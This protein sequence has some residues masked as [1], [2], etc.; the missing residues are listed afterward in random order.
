M[1]IEALKSRVLDNV[2][3]AVVIGHQSS[4]THESRVV[5]A[6][7]AFLRIAGRQDRDLT[8]TCMGDL[9]KQGHGPGHLDPKNLRAGHYDLTVMRADGSPHVIKALIAME[10]SPTRDGYYVSITC[11]QGSV[12]SVQRPAAPDPQQTEFAKL[13]EERDWLAQEHERLQFALNAYPDPFVIYDENLT[14]ISWNGAYAYTMVDDP[15]LLKRGMS[16]RDVLMLGVTNGRFPAAKENPEQWVNDRLSTNNLNADTEDNELENGSH[17]RLYRFRSDFGDYIVI[18]LDT[19]ELVRQKRV[20]ENAQSRLLAALNAYPAPFVI[21][22]PDDCIVVWNDAYSASMGDPDNPLTIGMHRNDVARIAIDAGKIVDA[23]GLE[24]IWKSAEH[25]RFDLKK[26]VQDLELPGDVHQR[27]LRSR[28]EN[29]DLVILR[30]DTTELV[31]QRRAVERYAERL[32]VA[33]HEITHQAFHDDLTGMGNR[34]HLKQR[35]EEFIEQKNAT[36]AEIAALHIDLDRFKQINDT[37]GHAAGDKVLLEVSKRIIGRMSPTDVVARIGG[38][39]FVVLT[40]VAENSAQP[41]ALAAQLIEDISQPVRYEDKEC[42]F[43][44]SIGVAVTPLSSVDQL[45]INSDIALYKA[46]GS[47]RGRWAVF[48][49]GDMEDLRHHKKT[50]DEICRGLERRE[51]I[52][53]FQPQVDAHTHEVVGIEVLARWDHPTHGIL[54]PDAFL[55]IATELDV[56]AEI[57]KMVFETAITDCTLA[58]ADMPDVPSLSFNVSAA[59]V[60][61]FQTSEF[62]QHIRGYPG[63]VAFELLE[64][65]FLEE[66]ETEFFWMLDQLRSFGIEIEVDDFGS[67]RASVVALQ[68]INPD[69]VKIDRRLVSP[70]T[71]REGSQQL[72]RSIVEIGH[73]L[74]MGVTA[75]GVETREQADL[76]A[77]L[78]CDRLQGYYF[79]KPLAYDD[80]LAYLGRDDQRRDVG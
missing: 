3:D 41:E 72:L 47:G 70:I 21:Y 19:T 50:A 27:L 8:D 2:S 43:G 12:Q 26:T 76:L 20:A 4:D 33:N 54:A 30:I 11:R 66:E 60:N 46:K 35:F 63:R 23:N 5:Y 37:I 56:V 17:Y 67:G 68:Q 6:N 45:L 18:R 61:S 40:F 49:Q 29:G 15:T 38:D 53:F 42:R 16:L 39:E 10:P 62:H 7:S 80:L 77:K 55:S 69:R 25:Q 59:R 71:I 34:R 78:G 74:E 22:D 44:A 13:V 36:G 1:T 52:P 14:L 51:F 75:E 64:T 73:A 65:I 48:D 24:E 28:V 32:E 58:F 79:A 57:D 9:F 31:R